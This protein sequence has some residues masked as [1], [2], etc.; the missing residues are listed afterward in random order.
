[1]KIHPQA[2][3]E[4]DEIGNGTCIWAFAH[5]MRGAKIG[6][7]VNV[8]DHTFIEGGAVI[9]NNVTIKNQ[10]CIWD[11]ITI[12]DDAFIGPRVTFTNDRYPRSPR[13]E[14]VK[15]RYASRE[16]WLSTTRVRTGCAI[17]AAATICPGVE[18]GPYSSIGAGAVVTRDVPPFALMLGT[19]ARQMGD[20]CTCGKPVDG[21]FDEATCSDCGETGTD[22]LAKLESLGYAF[23]RTFRMVFPHD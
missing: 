1:M 9:G 21:T 19:P 13:M 20:V 4:S 23:K 15:S 5:V 22:R 6:T 8:G 17:G 2:I 18:L 14:A 11:G 7:C 10:V 3:V 16:N 12:E